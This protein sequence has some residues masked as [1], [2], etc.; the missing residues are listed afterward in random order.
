MKPNKVIK[1]GFSN[2]LLL[3]SAMTCLLVIM[4]GVVCITESG[5]GC[6]DWPA[7]YGQLIPPPL[8][9]AIIEYTHR[10][11]AMLTTPL[12]IASAVI[13]WR[14]HRGVRWISRPLLAAVVL[15]FAVIVFGAL[16]VLR[17]LSWWAATLD[18]GSALLVLALMVTAA[19]VTVARR[20][21][22]KQGDQLVF[23]SP[24]SRL[25]LWA[26]ALTYV[27]LL[28]GIAAANPGSIE[29][30]FGWP[31][32]N[33]ISAP[34]DVYDWLQLARRVVAVAAGILV[35]ATVI[36]TRRH[37]NARMTRTATW[38]AIVFVV[39]AV[40]SVVTPMFGYYILLKVLYSA[41]AGVT[42]ALLTALLVQTG[43]ERVEQP[44]N[45]T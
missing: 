28:S 22:T 45:A 12:I 7:C 38:L 23:K 16:A 25:V 40:V 43:L 33:G 44:D 27:T 3:S 37:H 5:A 24:L 21:D 8:A 26:A 14:R 30:C 1:K 17:G 10:F 19:V 20:E 32:F 39:E 15:T 13:G 9:D 36:Q 4:G 29:R 11:V 35:I 34:V 18:L 2:L 6:P 31:M 42:W 41:A